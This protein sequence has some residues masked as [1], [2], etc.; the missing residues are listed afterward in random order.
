AVRLRPTFGVVRR[1]AAQRRLDV[2]EGGRQANDLAEL[3]AERHR[4]FSHT[5]LRE[6]QLV[7]DEAGARQLQAREDARGNPANGP[8]AGQPAH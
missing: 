5:R 4:Q 7:E 2:A 8:A 3:R 1:R 6:G